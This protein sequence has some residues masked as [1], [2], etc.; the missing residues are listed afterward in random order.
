MSAP[1]GVCVSG[2]PRVEFFGSI[3]RPSC[4]DVG[5][6]RRLPFVSTGVRALDVPRSLVWATDL[7]VLP[8][9]HVV[10]RRD[11][12]LVVR[13]PSNPGHYWGNLLVFNDPP[14]VGD[15]SGWERW[16][17]LEFGSECRVEHRTFAWDR[18]DGAVGCAQEEFVSR[19]Y[20]LEQTVGLVATPHSVRSHPREN[21]EVAVR[22]LDPLEDA[23]WELWEQV[24]ELQVAGRDERFEEQVH[25]NF[26]RRRSP[27]S[28]NSTSSRPG[29]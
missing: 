14:A 4:T 1:G 28:S 5:R 22:E 19:G 26:S 27:A 3:L 7:D 10:E 11:S 20:D 2:A 25:R 24:L 23:D 21:R 15:G 12:Y 6:L 29:R 16:F 18:V 13:S 17:E 9:D 8:F